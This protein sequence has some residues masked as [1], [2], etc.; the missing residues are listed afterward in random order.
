MIKSIFSFSGWTLW[1]QLAVVGSA[2]GKNILVNIF[3]SVSANAA[4]GVAHQ[5]NS[6]LVSLTSSFQTAFQ[7][8]ITKSYA[9]GDYEYMNSLICNASKVSFFLLF[10]VSLPFM[11]NINWVLSIWLTEVPEYSGSFCVLYIIASILNAL[12]TPLWISIFATGNIRNY[13]IALSLAYFTEIAVIYILFMLGFPPTT[14]MVVKV[15]LNAFMVILRLI[16]TKLEVDTFSVMG[17]IKKVLLPILISIILTL[18][19]AFILYRFVDSLIQQFVATFIIFVLSV[20]FAYF[21]GLTRSEQC[22]V[23]RLILK[24]IKRL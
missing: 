8:Q 10:I 12:A 2:Q 22:T 7:P 21:I 11:L 15:F 6:A 1:G 19:T 13:Q 18:A 20:V 16:Y 3:Y 23:K 4:M 17:Y 5:V 14:A 9:A 24:K